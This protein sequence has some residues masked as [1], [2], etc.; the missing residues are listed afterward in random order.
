M[1]AGWRNGIHD[2][3]L[4]C[5]ADTGPHSTVGHPNIPRHYGGNGAAFMSGGTHSFWTDR[6]TGRG[7][8]VEGQGQRA[9]CAARRCLRWRRSL[10]STT[11]ATAHASGGYGYKQIGDYF[12]VHFSTA[13]RI[14]RA[15][16]A[17]GALCYD[18]RP[19]RRSSEAP[20][21][22]P[23]SAGTPS[24]GARAPG[25]VSSIAWRGAVPP[26]K[27]AARGRP[28][29]VRGGRGCLGSGVLACSSELRGDFVGRFL[30]GQT[31][32]DDRDRGED[33]AG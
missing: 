14:V 19:D 27:R 30:G 8:G 15:A 3:P 5:W 25:E 29:L 22:T 18:D 32:R 12:G 31:G 23:W 13:E 2:R 24:R 16:K 33:E 7:R 21:C 9:L 1:C 17:R 4:R 28:L 11:I 6:S 20:G 26:R 10:V